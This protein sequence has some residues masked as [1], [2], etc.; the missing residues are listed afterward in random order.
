MIPNEEKE[1][2]QFIVV[3]KLSALLHIKTSKHED[4]FYCLNCLNFFR[5]DNKLKSHEKKCK[6]K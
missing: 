6:N 4:D 3:K 1:G 5:T 2:Y